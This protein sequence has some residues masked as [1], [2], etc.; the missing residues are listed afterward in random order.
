VTRYLFDDQLS[1]YSEVIGS[2]D[3][4]GAM[5][6][7]WRLDSA[8]HTILDYFLLD[9]LLIAR[10]DSLK[11]ILDARG[12]AEHLFWLAGIHAADGDTT[13]AFAVLDSIN[14]HFLTSYSELASQT[15]ISEVIWRNA[16]RHGILGISGG[17]ADSLAGYAQRYGLAGAMA[18]NLLAINQVSFPPKYFLPGEV[19]PRSVL[20]KDDQTEDV[21][22]FI[23]PNPASDVL[24]I[25]MPEGNGG[26]ALFD[27]I[28]IDGRQMMQGR[29]MGEL[30]SL[31]IQ[32]MPSGFYV[33]KVHCVKG[34]I[35]GTHKFLK[36]GMR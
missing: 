4:I 23:R 17:Y 9:T 20:N 3:T 15:E 8:T 18:R 31:G 22:V 7:R 13:E 25:F 10:D 1:E 34:G 32:D 21:K 11:I 36:I 28:S 27:I 30:T 14:T 33:I 19:G 6:S 2:N 24:E 35:I 16:A 29:L 5:E 12:E 26:D